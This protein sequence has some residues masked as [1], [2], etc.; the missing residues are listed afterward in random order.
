MVDT[1]DFHSVVSYLRSNLFDKKL[2]LNLY[3]TRKLQVEFEQA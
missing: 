2:I 3:F 1:S